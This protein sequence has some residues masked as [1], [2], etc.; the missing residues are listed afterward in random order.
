MWL[1][2]GLY[3][4]ITNDLVPLHLSCTFISARGCCRKL[5]CKLPSLP[6]CFSSA[7]RSGTES[8][9][10]LRQLFSSASHL[11]LTDHLL[12]AS[13]LEY[14]YLRLIETKLVEYKQLIYFWFIDWFMNATLIHHWTGSFASNVVDAWSAVMCR[15]MPRYLR[16]DPSLR[17]ALRGENPT[18]DM[19][20]FL[21]EYW[22]RIVWVHIPFIK[23]NTRPAFQE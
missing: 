17:R 16:I 19:I 18:T 8:V 21:T 9:I 13:H 5:L 22:V 14:R 23:C 10:F 11:P 15:V 3:G 12:L 4:Q 20:V 2:W 6:I 1:G 7:V